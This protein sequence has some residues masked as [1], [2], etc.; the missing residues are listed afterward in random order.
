LAQLPVFLRSFIA[1][2]G[3]IIQYYALKHRGEALGLGKILGPRI[4]ECQCQEWE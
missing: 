3:Q 4:G 2:S 1:G